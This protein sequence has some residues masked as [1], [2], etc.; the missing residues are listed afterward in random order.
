MQLFSGTTN[1]CNFI[2]LNLSFK[3]KTRNLTTKF[4]YENDENPV[5]QRNNK[6]DDLLVFPS[7]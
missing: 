2:F 3:I 5:Q 6:S 4:N 1:L 7:F